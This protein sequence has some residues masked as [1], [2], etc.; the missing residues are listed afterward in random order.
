MIA[1]GVD[2]QIAE[3]G[4]GKNHFNQHR[5]PE[6]ETALHP[7]QAQGWQSGIGESMA[8]NDAVFAD[9]AQT[10]LG[11]IILV[12]GLQQRGPQ[13]AHQQGRNTDSQ[14]Q[15]WQHHMRQNAYQ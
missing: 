6:H 4:I 11:D 7:D 1:H 5:A 2:H 15:C 8:N 3:T 9:A 13:H 10:G 14:R 12:D